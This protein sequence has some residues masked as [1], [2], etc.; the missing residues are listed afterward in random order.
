ME[1]SS[2]KMQNLANGFP[3]GQKKSGNPVLGMRNV[4]I[5]QFFVGRLVAVCLGTRSTRGRSVS[6]LA[7]V[8]GSD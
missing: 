4:K 1:M 2:S 3:A 5:L 6:T 8:S 7:I